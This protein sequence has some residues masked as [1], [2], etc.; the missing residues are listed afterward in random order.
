MDLLDVMLS[1]KAASSRPDVVSLNTLITHAKLQNNLHVAVDI[2][3]KFEEEICPN[4]V[5]PNAITYHLLF[6]LGWR[7]KSP[8]VVGVVWRYAC[9]VNGTSYRMRKRASRLLGGVTSRRLI[10]RRRASSR[11]ALPPLFR[12]DAGKILYNELALA[13]RGELAEKAKQIQG[14]KRAISEITKWYRVY[15]SDREP[16]VGLGTLL[17]EAVE[18]DKQVHSDV[19]QGK[20]VVFEPLVLPTKTRLRPVEGRRNTLPMIKAAEDERALSG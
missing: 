19:K 14:S 16:A 10:L 12:V 15:Y 1:H 17:K 3:Q 9:L 8:N 2:L 7:H 13:T 5:A 4:G 18:K 6:E 20:A 11:S